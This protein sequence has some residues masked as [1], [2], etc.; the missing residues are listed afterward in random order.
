[1]TMLSPAIWLWLLSFIQVISVIILP[2]EYTK[3]KENIGL[4]DN[5]RCYDL[6]GW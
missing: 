5:L 4:D 3:I 1:M 6:I 2:D